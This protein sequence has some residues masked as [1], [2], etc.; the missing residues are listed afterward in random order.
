MFLNA[1]AADMLGA[2]IL[3]HSVPTALLATRSQDIVSALGWVRTMI[4]DV[5][6]VLL[7]FDD[8]DL[9]ELSQ[10][11]R[12]ISNGSLLWITF[13]STSPVVEF[14]SRDRSRLPFL[15]FQALSRAL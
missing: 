12:A 15:R 11:G 4:S 1:Q 6:N 7:E 5:Q 10:V 2:S 3:M 9:E 8:S 14:A 13:T